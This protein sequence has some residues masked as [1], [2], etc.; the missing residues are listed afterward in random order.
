MQLMMYVFN[1]CLQVGAKLKF[2]VLSLDEKTSRI[3]L[4]H[5]KTLVSIHAI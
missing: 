2:R 1:L 5:K 4:T 3:Q